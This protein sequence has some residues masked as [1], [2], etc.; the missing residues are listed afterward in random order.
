M[1]A[2]HAWEWHRC[3]RPRDRSWAAGVVSRSCCSCGP[4]GQQLLA[5]RMLIGP[6]A[7][8]LA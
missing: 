2:M 7:A 1:G 4:A 6:R 3:S 5:L 8:A